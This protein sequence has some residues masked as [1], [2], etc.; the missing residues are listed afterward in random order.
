LFPKNIFLIE[1]VEAMEDF[2][3]KHHDFDDSEVRSFNNEFLGIL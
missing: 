3:N 1:D 2:L